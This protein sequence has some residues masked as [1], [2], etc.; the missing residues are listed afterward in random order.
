M[1]MLTSIIGENAVLLC[2]K[3][4]DM[5]LYVKDYLLDECFTE[6]IDSVRH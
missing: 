3:K 5:K 2:D 1:H 6:D 4:I